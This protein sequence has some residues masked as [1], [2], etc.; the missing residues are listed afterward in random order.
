MKGNALN[1]LFEL[2]KWV[3]VADAAR[4]LSIAFGEDVAEADVLKLALDEHLKISVR[5]VNGVSARYCMPVKREDV[6]RQAIPS[7]DGKGVIKISKND[8]VWADW[9]GIF[10]VYPSVTSLFGEVWDLPMTDG[11]RIDVTRRYQALTGGPDVTAVAPPGSILVES[12]EVTPLMLDGELIG[13]AK[14]S[15]FEIQS[16]SGDSTHP[17][18]FHP[19]SELPNDS[20][21]VVRTEA[22]REFEKSIAG[23]G[24]E[25]KALSTTERNSL[26]KMVIGMAIR[27][28][29]YDPVAKK[30][31]TPGEISKDLGL[32]GMKL[33]PETVLKFLREATD[34]MLPAK[35]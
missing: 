16:Y 25:E 19:A 3:T 12:T 9:R 30:S 17:D 33:D 7:L 27:G 15:L 13:V 21:L 34:K 23:S 18:S 2:A 24:G 28:Y 11:G 1:K 10:L 35:N 8:R 32:L 31:S 26:L 6:E 22:L 20:V 5:F 14:G 4:Y 29:G